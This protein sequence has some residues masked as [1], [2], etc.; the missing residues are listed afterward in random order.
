VDDDDDGAAAAAAA[1]AAATAMEG[2]MFSVSIDVFFNC[3]RT[4]FS[5]PSLS[6]VTL[7]GGEASKWV[8][9]ML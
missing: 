8:V 4:G 2:G 5:P 7:A 1:A 3:S 6:L 9:S